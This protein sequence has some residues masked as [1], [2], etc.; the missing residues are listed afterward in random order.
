M[1]EELRVSLRLE[2]IIEACDRINSYYPD[3]QI[4]LLN[5]K[6][7]EFFGLVKNLEIIGE[8]AYMLTNE[9]KESKP[10]TEW[11]PIIAMQHLLVHG[12][13]HISPRIVK[14]IIENDLPIFRSQIQ[15][16]LSELD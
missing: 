12:Y 8:A 9:F 14:E 5:E 6:S 11:Q 2:H 4:P 15:S 13:Y 1:R 7:I 16:Y 3:G 10:D